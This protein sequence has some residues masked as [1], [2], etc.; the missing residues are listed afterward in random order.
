VRLRG[1]NPEPLMSALGHKRTF[2]QFSPM[3]ALPPRADIDRDR[4]NAALCQAT[5]RGRYP[6]RSRY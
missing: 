2:H 5:N 3:S 4:G 1:C 6:E